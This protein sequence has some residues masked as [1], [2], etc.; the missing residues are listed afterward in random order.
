MNGHLCSFNL[1]YRCLHYNSL[2]TDSK[3]LTFIMIVTLHDQIKC[4]DSILGIMCKYDIIY[5]FSRES[6]S[7]HPCGELVERAGWKLLNF[8]LT[9]V[10][11]STRQLMWELTMLYFWVA[12][13]SCDIWPPEI[14][15]PPI[16]TMKTN[17]AIQTL[18]TNP[19]NHSYPEPSPRPFWISAIVDNMHGG[20]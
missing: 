5:L 10:Q 7:Q 9:E 18:E 17:P 1:Y 8:C 4:Y 11:T 12:V 16:H 2:L 20:P 6:R 15:G 14:F 13:L 3:W 19:A